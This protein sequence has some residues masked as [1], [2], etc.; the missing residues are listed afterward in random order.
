M[1]ERSSGNGRVKNSFFPP[2]A[3]VRRDGWG[4]RAFRRV[5]WWK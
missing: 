5:V 1:A 3:Q 4:T 2:I